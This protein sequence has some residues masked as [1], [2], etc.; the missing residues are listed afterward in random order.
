MSS[1]GG[2][3]TVFHLIEGKEDPIKLKDSLH[4]PLT[5]N[6]HVVS[7]GESLLISQREFPDLKIGDIIEICPEDELR[8]VVSRCQ[9]FE[10]WAH[11]ERVSSGLVTEDTKI[12]YRSASSMFY[13]FIQMS[14]EMWEFDINGE[15]YIE[16][17]FNGFLHDLF[18]KWKMRNCNHDVTI[19]LFSRT[20]YKAGKIEEFPQDMRE[21]LHQDH[22]GRFYED[23]YRVAVQNERFDDWSNTLVLLKKLFLQYQSL[24]LEYHQRRLQPE[25][26]PPAYNSTASEGNFLEVLNM[27]LNVF[28]KHYMDRSFDRTGQLSV[29]ISPGV[30]VFEVDRELANI[31]KQRTI[32]N[33]IPPIFAYFIPNL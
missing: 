22:R 13:L 23:Y 19:V 27:S 10:L 16:K 24:V 9:V 14:S 7:P 28:E 20:F 18:D 21:C 26:V 2:C 15:L 11:G 33:G 4:Y 32:D 12:V 29:V 8:S 31:T 3:S 1:H 30:G 6:L 5:A 25:K 17:A